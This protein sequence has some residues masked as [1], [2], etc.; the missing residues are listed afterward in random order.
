VGDFDVVYQSTVFTS[1]LDPAIQERLADRMWRCI[2]P[3]GFV[4]WYDGK[5]DNPSNRDV[6][7]VGRARVR[8]LFPY[9]T[10]KA[11]SLTLAP[12][13]ARRVVRWHPAG[14]A[15]LNMVPLFR[16]HLLC[17]IRKPE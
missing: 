11:R 2:R 3:G 7:G 14:Y 17:S 9:G 4:L 15:L 10:L 13:L 1:I 12:P 16:T 8:D 5:Y 6:R